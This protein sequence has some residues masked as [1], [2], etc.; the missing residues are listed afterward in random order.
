MK[1]NILTLTVLLSA[2]TIVSFGQ[3]TDDEK[4]LRALTSD[5]TQGWKNGGVLA[6]TLAQ[7]SLKNWSA[8]GQNSIAVSGVF[9]V[10]ANL[11]Q[12]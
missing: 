4:K 9:S 12:G 2:I 6:V 1:R 5:T 8:G 10:F 3:V 7:T 11:L